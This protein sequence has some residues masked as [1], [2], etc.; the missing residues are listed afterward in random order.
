[1][2][3]RRLLGTIGVDYKANNTQFV[4]ASKENVTRLNQQQKALNR[5]RRQ[6]RRMSNQVKSTVRQL[7]S[8]RSV[9][10]VLAG[11]GGLNLLLRNQAQFGATLVETGR[12]IGVNVESLQLLRRVAEADG[13]AISELDNSLRQ[14]SRRLGDSAAGNQEYAEVF[15]RL[16]IAITDNAG[17]TRDILDVFTDASAAISGL[18][19]QADRAAAAY[20]LFG[21]QGIRLLP[22]LQQGPEALARQI[23]HFRRF[24]ILTQQ[25]AEDLK[26]LEQTYTDLSNVIRI[27]LAR[28]VANS[29]LTF[30]ELNKNIARVIPDIVEPVIQAISFLARN[31]ESVVFVLN[32]LIT[33]LIAGRVIR[34]IE[35][36]VKAF[37]AYR[38][39]LLSTA[40]ASTA[41][42]ISLQAL[43]RTLGRLTL[44]T[45]AGFTLFEGIKYL[46]DQ[47]SPE[48]VFRDLEER[49]EARAATLQ[50]LGEE[51]QRL[52]DRDYLGL[53]SASEQQRLQALSQ[54]FEEVFAKTRQVGLE[55]AQL[56]KPIE[57]LPPIIQDA[58]AE[59][60]SG[61]D[62]VDELTEST[63]E[64]AEAQV[65]L[66]EAAALA[67]LKLEDSLARVT[68]G[69]QNQLRS[70]IDA[71]DLQLA[72]TDQERISI[73]F[74][75]I[76]RQYEQVRLNLD[77]Q[78]REIDTKISTATDQAAVAKLETDRQAIIDQ[79]ALYDELLPAEQIKAMLLLQQKEQVLAET[80][81]LKEA[82]ETATR[83]TQDLLRGF[84]LDSI[85][86]SA[87][88]RIELLRRETEE[89][90]LQGSALAV[91]EER[92]QGE[93]EVLI[94]REK[95]ANQLV[96]AQENLRRAVE[97]GNTAQIAALQ[98]Q[99]KIATLLLQVA[100]QQIPLALKKVEESAIQ[101]GRIVEEQIRLERLADIARSV[102]EAFGDFSGSIIKDFNDI[103]EAARRLGQTII[104]NLIRNL[105]ASPISNAITTLLGGALIPGLATGGLGRGLTI[106]GERG[107]ELVDFRN[108]GRVY[109]NED[110]Q[111]SISGA[112]SQN[113]YFAPVIQTSDSTAVQ[114]ALAEA[115]PIF[116]QQIMQDIE[117]NA[118][119]PSRLRTA[120]RR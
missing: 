26:E 81:A 116:Q 61:V 114:V 53:A 66:A 68:E 73:Q 111:A 109:S 75:P 9:V 84:S 45:A 21:R 93:R 82:G 39:V 80:K 74:R 90:G 1:M 58:V 10:G 95:V 106:V 14:L 19:D 71:R 35:Q 50:R 30:Q 62:V 46:L 49:L 77:K 24:G 85:N 94:E 36:L 88:E 23:E 78:L 119:R 72:T 65:N 25:Q 44:V 7:T 87:E 108:P 4:K 52:G 63:N 16:N 115:F 12:Q 20:D 27:N 92:R 17:R 98:E 57:E 120:V 37:Q 22:I 118:G 11:G 103:G 48:Q 101:A 42:S 28:A 64:A 70:A 96:R 15:E 112:G 54:D 100:D 6:L 55:L 102:G 51:I 91:L 83:Q 99:V 56:G 104:D 86:R 47:G 89:I 13:I 33:A 3:F 110:L 43:F 79:L 32:R 40:A 2:P 38:A 31:F 113:F 18:S 67:A 97:Q 59:L 34:G 60:Q 41:L 76:L 5:Y 8:F 69:L 117:I 107:P 29:S 105:I